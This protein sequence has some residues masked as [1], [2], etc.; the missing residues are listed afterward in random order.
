MF[1]LILQL[2]VHDHL[3][4]VVGQDLLA[5]LVQSHLVRDWL[6]VEFEQTVH[7]GVV[8]QAAGQQVGFEGRQVPRVL[9]A[10]KD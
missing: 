7:R 8:V 9:G 2:R 10:E 5:L 4:Q 6:L 3:L 1:L